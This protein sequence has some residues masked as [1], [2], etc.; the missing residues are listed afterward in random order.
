MPIA[1]WLR[2]PLR[3]WAGDL[4]DPAGIR[5]AG[6]LDATRVAACWDEHQRGTRN[7][8]DLLWRLLMFQAWQGSPARAEAAVP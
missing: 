6:L 3:D 4:L 5:Q 8:L 1:A 2:G 7:H